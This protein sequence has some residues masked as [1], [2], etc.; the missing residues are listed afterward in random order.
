MH[1]KSHR[2]LPERTIGLLQGEPSP[3]LLPAFW[4]RVCE[5]SRWNTLAVHSYFVLRSAFG[6]LPLIQL[7]S[8]LVMLKPCWN[9]WNKLNPTNFSPNIDFNGITNFS[10][11]GTV[12]FCSLVTD[13]IMQPLF[14]AIHVL[15]TSQ[16]SFQSNKSSAP[17]FEFVLNELITKYRSTSNTRSSWGSHRTHASLAWRLHKQIKL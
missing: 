10:W 17:E 13:A 6:T 7:K 2:C 5:A 4:R 11:T 3:F 1:S 8:S 14:N 9:K 15:I 16:A 12:P